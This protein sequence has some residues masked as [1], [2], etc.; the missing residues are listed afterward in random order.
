M[1]DKTPKDTGATKRGKLRTGQRVAQVT[2]DAALLPKSGRAKPVAVAEGQ[3]ARVKII[4]PVNARAA[5]GQQKAQRQALRAATV[6][7]GTAIE[8]GT[9]SAR[10]AKQLLVG[11][12]AKKLGSVEAAETWYRSHHV[13]D[14]GGRTPAQ[15]V[16][17]GEL[18]AL[19]AHL[20]GRKADTE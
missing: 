10:G 4:S 6:R 11:Q 9:L 17:A 7:I 13:E 3:Q 20:Q 1:N 14:L 8:D 5:A 2:V 19:L 15:M 18:K 16:R 12:M